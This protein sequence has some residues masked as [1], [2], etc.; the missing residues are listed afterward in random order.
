[1]GTAT[2]LLPIK[3]ITRKLAEEKILFNVGNSEAGPAC[4]ALRKA[5]DDVLRGREK[6]PEGWTVAVTEA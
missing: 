1:M 6:G 3:S 2:L 5:I 4:E